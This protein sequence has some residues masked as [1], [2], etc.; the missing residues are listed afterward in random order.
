MRSSYGFQKFLQ[1]IYV[2]FEH[3]GIV[4]SHD[5]GAVCA[6]CAERDRPT[7]VIARERVCGR[8]AGS[9]RIFIE[10]NRLFCSAVAGVVDC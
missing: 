1:A 3:T 7:Q 9:Q 4:T 10:K 6:R 2:V 8:V 5:G